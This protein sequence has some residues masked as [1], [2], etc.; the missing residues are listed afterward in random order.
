MGVSVTENVTT[1]TATGDV[2]VEITENTT[3]VAVSDN[4]ATLTVTPSETSVS[5][6]GNTT[7]INVTSADTAIN[8]TSDSIGT[9]GNQRIE[10]GTLYIELDKE[11]DYTDGVYNDISRGLLRLATTNRNN[12]G[13]FIQFA[14]S[15]TTNWNNVGGI[16]MAT[17][18]PASS[19]FIGAVSV[20]LHFT[21]SGSSAFILPC[22]EQGVSKTNINLGSTN[23][24]FKDIYSQDGTVS[25]SDKTKKTNIEQLN[26]AE[27]DVAISCKE[28]LRKYKWKT[29]V[30]EKG[31]DA[32]WHFGIMAQDLQTAFSEGGLDAHDYG[33][34][35]KDEKETDGVMETTYAV[36]YNELLAF[37]IAA[38]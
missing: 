24:T 28:L 26:Q 12:A 5:V 32:R 33:I 22:D 1:V 25:T 15:A 7:A 30:A 8:V 38:L 3:S 13:Q 23:T 34:F 37:I 9:S 27:K 11:S 4:T 2:T 10:Q 18:Q 20:G 35:I 14:D 17:N 29:A 19:L 6:S 21:A 36:R 16:G 31:D